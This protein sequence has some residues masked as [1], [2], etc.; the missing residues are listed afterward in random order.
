MTDNRITKHPILTP[1]SLPTVNFKFNGKP[2]KAR[3]GE[4]V[5]S[6][7]M[8]YGIAVFNTHH[9]DGAPQGIFC[10]NGQCAQ[11]LVLVNGRP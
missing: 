6:A 5:S 2:Y 8:A 4:P 10:A 9:K 3:P 1:D 7:M 11:C